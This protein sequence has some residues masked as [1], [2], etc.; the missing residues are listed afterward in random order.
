MA[1][2]VIRV[3]DL[4]GKFIENDEDLVKIIV[5]GHPIL[6]EDA[7]EIEALA[8]EVEALDNEKQFVHLEIHQEGEGPRSV[9]LELSEFEELAQDQP[10][11]KLL[12]TAKTVTT[13][14]A[15]PAAAA[16]K[17]DYATLEHAGKPKKGRTS[18]A[19]KRIVQEHFD[20]I[21]ERLQGE[22]LRT[23]DLS[24]PDHVERYGLEELA[25]ERLG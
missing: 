1:Q 17:I 24:N 14:S 8:E 18:D 16:A 23:I 10:M 12:T 4:T 19:E 13:R 2:R 11:D 15:R 9:V 22:G 3:S 6:G 25:K 21:N 7:V 5:R 20:Q